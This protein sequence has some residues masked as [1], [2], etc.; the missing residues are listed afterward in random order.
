MIHLSLHMCQ[1]GSNAL[2]SLK[3]RVEQ[4]SIGDSTENVCD[5]MVEG[6]PGDDFVRSRMRKE[7]KLEIAL[8][9]YRMRHYFAFII[10]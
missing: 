1:E 2:F 5:Y 10:T 7:K 8:S 6:Q 4:P 9:V 3:S